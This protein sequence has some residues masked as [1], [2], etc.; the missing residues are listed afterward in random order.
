MSDCACNANNVCE[1]GEDAK[2]CPRDCGVSAQDGM[3]GYDGTDQQHD[4]SNGYDGTDQQYDGS[5][6][7]DSM[8]T[9]DGMNGDGGG[10]NGMN[11]D[12]GGDNGGSCLTN[13]EECSDNLECCSSACDTSVESRGRTNCVG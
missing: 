3:N 11:S 5:N 1:P 9:Y 6:G 10:D 13:D 12:G 4:G 8:Y 7:Y 2:N